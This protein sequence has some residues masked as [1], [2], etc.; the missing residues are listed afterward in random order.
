MELMSSNY[1]HY[2]PTGGERMK[3]DLFRGA[4]IRKSSRVGMVSALNGMVEFSWTDLIQKGAETLIGGRISELAAEKT[5]AEARLAAAESD[6]RA[7]ARAAALQTADIKAADAAAARSIGARQPGFFSNPKNI[8]IV[9]GG[10]AV[11]V[12]G[13][14]V[15]KKKKAI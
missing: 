15:L 1:A 2:N 13:A 9:G 5:A 12:I 11:V 8:M 14:L 4:M 10:L 7:A 3:R 6:A